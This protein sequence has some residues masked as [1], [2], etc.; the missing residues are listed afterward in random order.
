MPWDNGYEY[1]TQRKK[2][3]WRYPGVEI[4]WRLRHK[5]YV[6]K[7][8][9]E[10]ARWRSPIDEARTLPARLLIHSLSSMLSVFLELLSLLK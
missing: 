4:P 8:S 6:A 5:Y 7:L 9:A 3:P 1:G 10:Q 2:K